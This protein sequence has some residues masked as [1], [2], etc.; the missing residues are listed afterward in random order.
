MTNDRADTQTGPQIGIF[1]VAHTNVGKTTLIRTLLGKDVGEIEDAPDVTR[2]TAAYDLVV[3]QEA[4]QDSVTASAWPGACGR[5]SAGSPGRSARSGIG[6]SIESC[7]GSSDWH[8][9]CARA[10]A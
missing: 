4:P 8:S 2:A 5:S 1:L 6:P 7:G 10:P 9:I 3:D